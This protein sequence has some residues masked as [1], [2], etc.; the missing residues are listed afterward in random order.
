MP[1]VCKFPGILPVSPHW[2]CRRYYHRE[3]LPVSSPGRITGHAA[4]V[5]SP[6]SEGKILIATW[7]KGT[8]KGWGIEEDQHLWEGQGMPFLCWE[9]KML[10]PSLTSCVSDRGGVRWML[11]LQPVPSL[12]RGIPVQQFPFNQLQADGMEPTSVGNSASELASFITCK[13]NLEIEVPHI[14]QL[15]LIVWT[16]QISRVCPD[17]IQPWPS[18]QQTLQLQI[19][20][21]CLWGGLVIPSQS[22]PSMIRLGFVPRSLSVVFC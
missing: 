16:S 1:G 6:L 11:V 4:S 5:I 22:I 10:H 2:T 18:V 8:I 14:R 19:W 15:L 20:I 12:Q 17:V 9:W 7:K 21:L 13:W 3:F